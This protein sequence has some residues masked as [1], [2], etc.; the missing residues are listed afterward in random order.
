M[1]RTTLRALLVF[2]LVLI[3]TGDCYWLIANVVRAVSGIDITS[4]S[5]TFRKN[6]LS[7]MD[8]TSKFSDLKTSSLGQST[9]G[10]DKPSSMGM[11]TLVGKHRNRKKNTQLEE[12]DEETHAAMDALHASLRAKLLDTMKNSCL[13]K[14]ICEL[15]ATPN[16]DKL[17]ESERALLSLIRETSIST[18]AETPSKYHFAAHMGLLISGVEGTGCYNFFPSCPFPGLQVLNMMKKIRITGI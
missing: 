5:P 12:D 18:R 6:S 11:A 1:E 9:E 4:N 15:N 17:T 2:S 16:K 13:P 8:S 7:R 14:L 10:G 3:M